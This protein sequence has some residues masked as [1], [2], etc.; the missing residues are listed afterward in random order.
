MMTFPGSL[1]WLTPWESSVH[2]SSIWWK[3]PKS[4]DFQEI[5]E[6]QILSGRILAGSLVPEPKSSLRSLCVYLL[7]PTRS[8]YFFNQGMLYPTIEVKFD[9]WWRD[10]NVK[11]HLMN[12]HPK[13]SAIGQDSPEIWPVEIWRPQNGL[14]RGGGGIWR[15]PMLSTPS[16]TD[17][18]F[19]PSIR[20]MK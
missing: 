17:L 11:E 9:V 16:R 18:S 7:T 3:F 13:T 20:C 12:V 15:R 1:Y 8:N 19:N 5:Q 2:R 4:D 6:V 10:G 14:D